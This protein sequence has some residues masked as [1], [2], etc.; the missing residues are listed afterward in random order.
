MRI[1]KFML[2][3]Y[4]LTICMCLHV[5]LKKHSQLDPKTLVSLL[6]DEDFGDNVILDIQPLCIDTSPS[7]QPTPAKP[8]N[9]GVRTFIGVRPKISK[10]TTFLAK[11]PYLTKEPTYESNIID[12]VSHSMVITLLILLLFMYQ[13]FML[14]RC[15]HCRSKA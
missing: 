1:L 6:D 5:N 10:S 9:S 14:K 12:H 15:Y 11:K 4:M 2:Q 8:T 3:C 13:V 7:G